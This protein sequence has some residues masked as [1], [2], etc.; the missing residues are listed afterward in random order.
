MNEEEYTLQMNKAYEVAVKQLTKDAIHHHTIQILNRDAAAP[1]RYKPGGSGV[2]TQFQDRYFIF[3]A[4]HVTAD[5]NGDSQLYINTRVGVQLLSGTLDETNL[6]ADPWADLAYI[7]LDRP[8]ALLLTETYKFLPFNKIE[9]GHHPT[10][11]PQYLVSGYPE[12]NIWIDQETQTITTGSSHF[13][14]TMA[15][16]N[17]YD[18]YNISKESCIVLNFAGAGFDLETGEK[19]KGIQD[20]YGI[21]GCGLW[22]IV[23]NGMR[24]DK[25]ILRYTLIGIM[26]MVKRSKY[27]VLIGNKI[28][29]ILQA[30]NEK[31][32]VI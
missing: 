17:P 32:V 31:G 8:L 3:T 10:E 28:E 6:D 9:V 24:N 30:L 4:S 23:P 26:F 20:P 16:T 21:S 29:I 12:R 2:L 7:E 27:H 5:N 15:N 18:Y 22:S 14:L 1:G 25:M 19:I 13:L 11:W